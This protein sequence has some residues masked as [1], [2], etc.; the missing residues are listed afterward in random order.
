MSSDKKVAAELAKCR[1]F[2]TDKQL[3]AKA[4]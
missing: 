4:A 2:Y 1:K 3:S